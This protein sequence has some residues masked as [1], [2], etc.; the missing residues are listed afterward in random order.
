MQTDSIFYEVFRFDPQSLP[1]L[2]QLKLEGRYEFESITVKTTEKRF[3]GFLRRIDGN[4]PYLFI[5]VQGYLDPKIYWKLYREICTFY[6]QRNDSTPFIAVVLFLDESFDPGEFSVT[7]LTP[8]QLLRA[9]LIECLTKLEGT[10]SALTALKPLALKT[11]DQAVAAA[12]QWKAEIK[13]LNLSES[14]EKYLIDLLIN[15]LTQ[16]FNELTEEE[17]NAMLHLTPLDQTTAGKQIYGRGLGHGALMGKIQVAQKIL[18]QPITSEDELLTKSS[19]ELKR[20]LQDLESKL[21]LLL[22][23]N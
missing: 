10:A 12:P 14:R 6:E 1:L 16:K 15:V 11:R 21:D 22:Q 19:D 3:D 20:I 5:E 17:I 23:V 7:C 2:L 9:N 13:V 4:R 8:C 18:R